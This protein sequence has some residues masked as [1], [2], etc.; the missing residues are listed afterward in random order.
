VELPCIL[1]TVDYWCHSMFHDLALCSVNLYHS[2]CQAKAYQPGP[3]LNAAGD[4]GDTMA[5]TAA[6]LK[7][8]A[9]SFHAVFFVPGNHDLWIRP[10]TQ[11][12]AYFDSFAKLFALKALC[13]QL[14][15]HTGPAMVRWRG[16]KAGQKEQGQQQGQQ[17]QQEL[18]QEVLVVPLLSWYNWQFDELDPR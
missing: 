9:G 3:C 8:L 15:V 12:E 10:G 5:A 4:V 2:C 16:P 17:Q 11:D 7:L 13:R 6:A 18:E 14:G 1:L